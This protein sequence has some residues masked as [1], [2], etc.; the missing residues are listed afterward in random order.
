MSEKQERKR[1][2]N[3]KLEFIAA[4]ERWISEEPPIILFWRWK[5]WKN[6]RPIWA[7]VE[8]KGANNELQK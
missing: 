6:S 5:K 3:L 2:Y 7:E 8:K 4:F 1:R